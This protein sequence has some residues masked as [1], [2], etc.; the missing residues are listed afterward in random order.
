MTNQ[1][2]IYI[3]NFNLFFLDEIR[4]IAGDP[5]ENPKNKLFFI[6]TH[7]P[8]FLDFRNMDDLYNIIVCHHKEMPTYIKRGNIDTQDE[9]VLKR[10]LPRFN[11]HHKQFFFSPNPVFV[12]GYTDQQIMTLLFEK[13]KNNIAS[14]GSCLID[15]GGK[16]ELAVF[17]RLC[18]KLKITCRIIADYDAMLRGKLREVICNNSLI[19]NSFSASGFGTDVSFRLGEFE[20][21]L[22]IIADDLSK[23]SSSVPPISNVIE[24]IK[25]ITG[26]TK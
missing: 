13:N 7:S 8:F 15:V 17:F 26:K 20:Q 19:Q 21:K 5:K 4:K 22:M 25:K 18:E 2:C 3:L 23:K 1:N 6:I 14:S 12:E 24:R 11:T 9:Y 16:D 10:F